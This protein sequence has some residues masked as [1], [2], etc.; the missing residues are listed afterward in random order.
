MGEMSRGRDQSMKAYTQT[1]T[2]G[3]AVTAPATLH[4][5]AYIQY[6][7]AEEPDSHKPSGF[8]RAKRPVR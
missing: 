6:I 5:P 8:D 1:H 7:Q 4:S 2:M 3:Q